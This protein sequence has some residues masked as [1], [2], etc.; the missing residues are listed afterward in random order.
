MPSDRDVPTRTAGSRGEGW[1]A[2]QLVLMAIAGAM[3]Y[4]AGDRWAL[5]LGSAGRGVGIALVAL[6]AAFFV[7]S[8]RALGTNLTAFPRPRPEGALVTSG[9]YALVRHPIYAAVFLVALG[10]SL[11]H[12]DGA[13][14][15]AALVLLVFFDLKSRREERWLVERFPEYRRYQGRVRKLVPLVY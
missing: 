12:D 14:L 11:L 2:V 5:A 4:L 6:G 7:A 15:G 9:A 1:V 8:A 10:W 13:T 3:P